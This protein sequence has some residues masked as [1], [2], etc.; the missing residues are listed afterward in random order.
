M[1]YFPFLIDITDKVCVIV[2]GG[3]VAFR[4]AKKMLDFDA[5]V[6]VIAPQICNQLYLLEETNDN[7]KVV[8]REFKD[9]DILEADIVIVATDSE[10]TNSHISKLCK[11]KNILVNVADMKEECSFIFPSIIR[12]EELIIAVSSGGNSPATTAFIKNKVREAIP[13][14]YGKMISEL[15]DYR[16]YIRKLVGDGESRKKIYYELVKYGD[17][18]NGDIPVEIIKQEVNKYYK[19]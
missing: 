2:G 4:K 8:V 5:R 9:E 14:Y 11:D 16:D 15:G 3:K 19:K 7:F 12:D 6:S 13:D 10:D 18:H 17:S 1:A